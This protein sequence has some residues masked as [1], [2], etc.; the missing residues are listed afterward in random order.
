MKDIYNM[1]FYSSVKNYLNNKNLLFLAFSISFIIKLILFF[2]ILNFDLAN[3]YGDQ[4]KYWELSDKIFN[5]ISYFQKEF[6]TMRVPLYPLF[7]YCLKLFNSSVYFVIFIQLIINFCV[8]YLIFEIGCL[9]NKSVGNIS[10]LI[11][12]VSLNLLNSSLFILTESIFLPFFLFYVLNLIKFL[13]NKNHENKYLIIASIFLGLA[14]LTRP[15]SLYFFI[16][17]FFVFF[18][19]KILSN[20]KSSIIFL[21]IFSIILSP[22][23]FRNYKLYDN[24]SLTNS[25]G[26]NLAGYYLP[27]LASNYQDKPVNLMRSMIYKEMRENINYNQNPFDY[28]K[29]ESKFFFEKIK[30][31][32]ISVFAETWIEGS[33]KFIFA[34][35]I[36]DFYYLFN[37]DKTNFSEIN[38]SSFIKSSIIYLFDNDNSYFSFLMFF[39][40][41]I[42]LVSRLFSFMSLFVIERKNF[43]LI[44][45]IIS[46][47]IL[48]L[49]IVG[50]I[51]SARY[52]IVVEPFLIILS[53]IYLEFI[54]KKYFKKKI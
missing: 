26:P 1:N 22:W 9:F 17:I 49:I 27:Y 11:S 42:I 51:G 37:F 14:T 36:I 7:L 47:I 28:S 32:P 53:S 25:A 52:R 15:I 12:S 48:N 19:K 35:P 38:E 34:P 23:C 39:S 43:L 29:E 33:L 5:E 21:V 50:P 24:Y 18:K 45:V 3:L 44:S 54:F 20:I 46:I 4:S 40:I 30:N 41:I 31:Y 2:F 6:G 16:L 8:L 13:K 10:I